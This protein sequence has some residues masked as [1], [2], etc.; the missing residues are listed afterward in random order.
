MGHH[1]SHLA[2]IVLCIIS[3]FCHAEK[4]TI[5]VETDV[6]NI[7][8]QII[9]DRDILAVK[10][11]S[12]PSAQRDVV[13]FILV[14]QALALGGADLN[15]SFTLGNYD[16]RNIKLLLDGS[17][18]INFD[19]MWLSQ[20]EKYSDDLY[21]SAPVINKG[22]YWAGLYTAVDNN[23]ALATKQLSDLKKLSVIS[24][25]NW[26]VD[27]KT[28]N[29]ISPKV[30]IHD[31]E[32]VSMAKLVSLKWVDVMLAPFNLKQ[33]FTYQGDDY[34]IVA[35]D[36][37]KVA[38]NDSRHF[39]VSKK[40]P[41]GRETFIALQKGMEQLRKQGAINKAYRESGFHN[42]QVKDWHVINA[43]L[44]KADK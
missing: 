36:K 8:Q 33:P 17:L 23:K 20:V 21:I 7:A 41:L 13:E 10:D 40:H 32:W 29:Q 28:L 44:I 27:W 16:A 14:Q 18:L 37:V 12:S 5:S 30:L 15:F 24:N 35:I 22:E 25:N 26:Y 3:A 6:Y 4:V 1:F 9:A 11:F 31:E 42:A 2:S 38:L 19:S 43:T 34:K 39:V